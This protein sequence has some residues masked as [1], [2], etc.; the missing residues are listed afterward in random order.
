MLGCASRLSLE[1]YHGWS[2]SAVTMLILIQPLFLVFLG[3]VPSLCLRLGYTTMMTVSLVYLY[4]APWNLLW[5][6]F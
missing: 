6:V 4:S 3:V 5:F 1:A 2:Q